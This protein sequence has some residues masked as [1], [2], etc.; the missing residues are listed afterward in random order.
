MEEQ[1]L[2]IQL[3]IM[4][5]EFAATENNTF[6]MVGLSS[7]N[8][9]NNFNTIQYAWYLR[10]DG[11]CEIF[12]TGASRGYF[13]AYLSGDLF[14]I[15]IESNVVKYYRNNILIF[16]SAIVP[17]LPL[18]VDVSINSVNGTITNAK[19]SNFYSGVFSAFLLMLVQLPHF[20]GN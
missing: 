9:N 4:V 10:G 2:G 13:G 11:V 7:S 5:F 20:S 3:K 1:L 17:T 19:I 15:S 8:T 12:E 6:R 14:K 18:L 16:T